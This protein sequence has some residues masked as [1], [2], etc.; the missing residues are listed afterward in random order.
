MKINKSLIIGV[1]AFCCN[2]A[3]NAQ[4]AK[5]LVRP[6]YDAIEMKDNGLLKVSLKGKIGLLNKD[7]EKVLPLEYDSITSFHEGKALLFNNNK[8]YGITDQ[9]GKVIAL[10]SQNYELFPGNNRFQ[11]G[12]LLVKQNN[13]YY[14]L[15]AKGSK[16]FGPYAEAYPFFDKHACVKS[17]VDYEKKPE[18][19]FYDFIHTT[20][21]EFNLPKL[22]KEDISFMS[23][24]HNGHAIIVIKKKF[25][26]IDTN[27]EL[28]P[29]SIDSTAQKESLVVA[30][31][32]EINIIRG[33]DGYRVRAKNGLF[34]FDNF[35]RPIYWELMGKKRQTFEYAPESKRAYT[36]R[37]TIQGNVHKQGLLLDGKEFLPLQFDRISHLEE[38]LAIVT[39]GGKCGVITV[40][41]NNQFI[42]KLNNNEN[43][44]FNHQYFDAKLT[45]LMPPYIKCSSAT[46]KSLSEGCEIQVESRSENE[47]VE[48]NTLAYNCRLSIPKDLTD[49]LTVHNY[50]YSLNYDGLV[51]IPHKV[52]ISEWYVKYYE[53]KLSNT[54]FTIS[55]INDTISVEFD[56]IKTDV[57]RND[58]SNYFKNIDV[59]SYN[60]TEQPILNKITENHYSLQ[61]FGIEQER[62]NFS[63]KITEI[64]CPTIEYPFEMI[65]KR[66]EPRKKNKK[67]TVT[68]TPIQKSPSFEDEIILLDD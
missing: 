18:D 39:I 14:Y 6:D 5:W 12:M 4:I 16:A 50:Y 19:T 49:T 1:I 31:K 61:L 11:N 10:Q 65:F 20:G 17:Y 29:I 27:H 22:D 15:N 38:K 67:T 23:S 43:I 30:E 64:G 33:N 24:F 66:P 41:E 55:S 68:I 46:I 2:S 60:M 35:M 36:S 25:Y 48:R 28:H 51:S 59:V 21:A 7:G 53:V 56:L 9:Y 58:E 40:D 42:F 47:N 44:G 45:A 13:Q 63:V 54:N 37:F 57:A 26:T 52:S 62:V 3:V 32:K 34:A 8:L